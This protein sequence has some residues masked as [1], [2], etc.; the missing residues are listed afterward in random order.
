MADF[1]WLDELPEASWNVDAGGGR[2]RSFDLEVFCK[3]CGISHGEQWRREFDL[4]G[5][6][7]PRIYSQMHRPDGVWIFRV[8]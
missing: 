7:H 1:S 6:E 3:K 5:A 8:H 2:S 4:W